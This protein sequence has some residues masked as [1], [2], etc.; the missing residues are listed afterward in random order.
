MI[1]FCTGVHMKKLG[2]GR[3][4][5]TDADVAQ[6][7][8]WC[9]EVVT[10]VGDL[11]SG[12]RALSDP[13]LASRTVRLR[14]LA[15]AGQPVGELLPEAFATVR[16][17]ARRV[18]GQRHHDVQIMA[19]AALERGFVTEMRT[20]EGKTLTATLPA[21]LNALAG[22]GV[23]VMTANQYLAN[24]DAEW[25]R[26]VYD[27]LGLR[28]GLIDGANPAVA[29][30][31]GRASAYQADITYG[32]AHEFAYDYLRDNLA[33]WPGE[34]VQ[35]G[36]QCA[37][38]D[39][40]DLIMIDDAFSRPMV[41]GPGDA[42]DMPYAA[43][44]T[45]AAGFE[46][47]VHYSVPP[48]RREVVL[49]DAGAEEAERQLGIDD[50]YDAANIRLAQGLSAALTAA[51]LYRR[52]RD[53]I[54]TD[55]RVVTID[56]TSGRPMPD[57]QP[58]D[59]V[60][61]AIEAKEGVEISARNRVLAVIPAHEYLKG[62]ARLMPMT[63]TAASDAPSYQ[64]IYGLDVM[65]IPANR[66][67]IRVD[68]PD[69]FCATVARKLRELMYEVS[70]RHETGQPLLIGTESIEKASAISGLLGERG[71]DHQVLTAK[72]NE[73]EAAIIAGAA[74][75]GAVTVVAKMAGRGIDIALGGPDASAADRQQV[76]D[77][78]GLCVL[79]ADRYLNRRLEMHLRGRA[80][81]QGDPGE[82]MLFT[83]FEDEAMVSVA[84]ARQ[85]AMNSRLIRKT[86]RMTSG[87]VTRAF[88]RA[89]AVWAA[90][91]AEAAKANLEFD[92][93]L[94]GQLD[95]VYRHREE[96]FGA[97]DLSDW[98]IGLRARMP[99]S[100]EWQQDAADAY[101]ER[102]AKLGRMT[103]YKVTRHVALAAIDHH[104][105]EH[106]EEMTAL[107]GGIGLAAVGG[108]SP[109]AEYRHDAA[110]LFAKMV[111]SADLITVIEVFRNTPV[112]PAWLKAAIEQ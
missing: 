107:L 78:G 80:G 92:A 55:G 108:R 11:E 54:V 98:I 38:V 73:Q 19:G 61:Q 88:D 31:T 64:V 112:L 72:N 8:G 66:P 27:F 20:G 111:R 59:G 51:A 40:A 75:L 104:W 10:R 56:R 50:L 83:S 17:A 97:D 12:L 26:P 2:H 52:D 103:M 5:G 101:A 15:Q 32:V 67:V 84:G 105:R 37:I 47:D 4:G 41:S 68:H 91:S 6:V 30:F 85:A 99:R 62:Y 33:F 71:I 9:H 81:R 74:R 93:V 36:R 109:I 16:E 79:G 35:R 18:L 76:A 1:N 53:Y 39:E 43:L 96:I 28:T 77:L 45:I 34:R 24:R 21:Y 49:T 3:P 22:G 60:Y 23:H 44:A 102:E 87:P 13:G 70:D 58:V 7:P 90:T 65:V 14:V 86:P 106:L 100:G 46:P 48:G 110:E 29:G 82:S 89:Q 95:Q 57:T 94:A 63:G 69:V 25:M 42:D